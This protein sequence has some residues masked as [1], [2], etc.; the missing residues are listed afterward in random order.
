MG[1]YSDIRRGAELNAALVRLRAYEDLTRDQKQASYKAQRGTSIKVNPIRVKGYVEAF[2]LTGRIYL[3]VKLLAETGQTTNATLIGIVRDAV[4]TDGRTHALGFEVPAGGLTLDGLKGFKPA[5]V[6]LTDR[7]AEV[8]DN[9]SR[10][11]DIQYKRYDNKS[12]SSP[13]GSKSTGSELYQDAVAAISDIAAV[14][15]FLTS[16]GNRIAFTPE[17]L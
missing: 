14:K 13:F 4:Q 10:I 15:N 11:T 9:K 2:G 17:V 6:S 7:G 1:R 8:T 5:K 12:V 3:P 16:P